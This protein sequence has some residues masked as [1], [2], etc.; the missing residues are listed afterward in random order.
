[1]S[2]LIVTYGYWAL[3][4]LVAAG[5]PGIPLPGETALIIASAHAGSTHRLSPDS[6]G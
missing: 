1:M 5:C 3:F 4:A 2:H 6:A